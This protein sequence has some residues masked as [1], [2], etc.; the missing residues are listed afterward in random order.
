M[1]I[2]LVNFPRGVVVMLFPSDSVG[3]NHNTLDHGKVRI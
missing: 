3:V 2:L 1:S